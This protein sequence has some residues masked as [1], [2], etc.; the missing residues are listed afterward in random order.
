MPQCKTTTFR[1]CLQYVDADV[2]ILPALLILC[3]SMKAIVISSGK[4]VRL[5]E[6]SKLTF[7][8][9]LDD[10]TPQILHYT[11]EIS[12]EFICLMFT[13]SL[14]QGCLSSDWKLFKVVPV[15][16]MVVALEPRI[17]ALYP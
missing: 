16:K 2:P 7:T 5:T 10:I 12:S 1:P 14:S 9:G 17:T 15:F 11:K 8:R 6:S 13:Q 3:E 4:I